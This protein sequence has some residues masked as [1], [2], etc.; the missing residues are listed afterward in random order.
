[1]ATLITEECINCGACEPACPNQAISEGDDIFVINP[2]RCT[3]CVGHFEVE[4][5][6]DVCPVRCCTTDLN[7]PE[8]EGELLARARRLH[9]DKSFSDTDFPSRFRS[10]QA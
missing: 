5:C 7:Y 10:P 8:A 4:Q 3:E 6:L 9:P 2:S 1:M